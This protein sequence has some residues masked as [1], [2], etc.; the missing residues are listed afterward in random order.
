M[1]SIVSSKLDALPACPVER[2][3]RMLSGRWR[4][5]VLFRLNDGPMRFN[6]LARSLAPISPRIL[7]HTLRDLE[8]EGLVWRRSKDSVPPHVSYGLTEDGEAL[9]PIFDELAKWWLNRHG[10]S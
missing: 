4:L 6:A 3:V 8:A 10:D 5:M 9:A 2:T 1:T 7:T